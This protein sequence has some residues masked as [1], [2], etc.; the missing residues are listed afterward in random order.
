MVAGKS[1][2]IVVFLSATHDRRSLPIA[3]SDSLARQSLITALGAE[4]L[5]TLNRAINRFSIIF[6]AHHR[7][8]D[9]IAGKE[10]DTLEGKLVFADLNFLSL[11]TVARLR[12]CASPAADTDSERRERTASVRLVTQRKLCKGS[13]HV[14]SRPAV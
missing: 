11:C 2:R 5:L 12:R 1:R 3:K 10:L 6:T 4:S 8:A 13:F 9:A 7:D 14:P